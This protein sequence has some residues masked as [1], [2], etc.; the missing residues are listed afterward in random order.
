MSSNVKADNQYFGKYRECCVVAYLNNS[1]IEYN[2]N[3]IF[4]EE[5]KKSLSKEA[6]LIANF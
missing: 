2:E 1:E 6:K 4:T 3:Y 5:E